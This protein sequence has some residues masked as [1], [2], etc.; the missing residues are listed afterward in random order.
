VRTSAIR[1]LVMIN[2]GVYGYAEVDMEGSTHLAGDN[3]LG[4]TSLINVFQF[5]YVDDWTL[6]RFPN[7]NE[8]TRKYYFK[9]NSYILIEVE[10]PGGI[11]LIGLRGLGTQKS[12]DY[13]RF[14]VNGPFERDGFMDGNQVRKW[15]DISQNHLVPRVVKPQTK[16]V[17]D[18]RELRN[19]LTGSGESAG[20]R[21]ELIPQANY[22]AF[23][24]MFLNLLSLKRT[25]ESD[26]KGMILDS[27]GAEIESR[28]L[29]LASDFASFFQGIQHHAHQL[30]L[31]EGAEPEGRRLERDHRT[32]KSLIAGLPM[33]WVRINEGL[34]RGIGVLRDQARAFEEESESAR[35]RQTVASREMHEVTEAIGR[36]TRQRAEAE[37]H[38]RTLDTLAA[39]FDGLD[40]K[41]IEDRPRTIQS[42][43]DPL[44][45]RLALQD[46]PGSKKEVEVRLASLEARR[47]QKEATLAAPDASW[48]AKLLGEC[49][50][51][52]RGT[53]LRIVHPELLA[54]PEGEDGVTVKDPGK[55]FAT[56]A[57]MDAR[58]KGDV[59]EDGGIRV[60]LRQIISPMQGVFDPVVIER[61]IEGLRAQEDKLHALLKDVASLESLKR[62]VQTLDRTYREA[63]ALEVRFQDWRKS[64][65]QR[66]DYELRLR[67]AEASLLSLAERRDELDAEIR[68]LSERVRDAMNLSRQKDRD[69]ENMR[70]ELS[71]FQTQQD[72]DWDLP[73]PGIVGPIP[74]PDDLK[75]S[76]ENYRSRFFK[77]NSSYELVSRGLDALRTGLGSLLPGADIDETMHN[78]SDQLDSIPER[79]KTVLDEKTALVGQASRRFADFYRG[80]ESVKA[81]VATINRGLTEVKVSNLRSIELKLMSTPQADTIAELANAQTS[82][83]FVTEP[84]KVD[85]A[86]R[87]IVERMEEK[88]TFELEDLFGLHIKVVKANGEAKLYDRADIDST[89]TAM[90]FKV[91]LIARMIREITK[92]RGSRS[93]RLPLFVDEADTLDDLN[94]TTILGLA[95]RL[96]FS[97]IMASPNALPAHRV[98][99]LHARDGLTWITKDDEHLLLEKDADE[100]L[101]IEFASAEVAD[102]A[103]IP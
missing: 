16:L 57:A 30:K 2:S 34:H 61:E 83:I 14:V 9:E 40:P 75:A 64:E 81:W 44:R 5:F 92:M 18:R 67:E 29:N 58:V 63:L 60:N 49:D 78:L 26:L 86:V 69:A 13:E 71:A 8:E 85:E 97:V 22:D 102:A 77:A 96:G 93:I 41:V 21:L 31:I 35:E 52:Q 39:Q 24:K 12:H 56:I 95:E 66:Q 79:R 17:L 74:G 27:L 15:E 70:A 4:K 47:K 100:E 37:T 20:V 80:F 38:L 68:D 55:V 28:T 53:V 3:N 33:D 7:T 82:P 101:G 25:K 76:L 72:P 50:E 42:L 62:E 43:L 99:L 90:T 54:L 59:Y 45:G 36:M 103:P 48:S 94:R 84:E 1:K 51:G 11:R 89:G 46:D 23:V 10:T 98:Y 6:M 73:D 91:V 19:A 87:R 65:E 88:Q 32:Y